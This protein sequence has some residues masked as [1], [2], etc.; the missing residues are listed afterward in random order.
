MN[1]IAVAGGTGVVGRRAVAALR[2]R[3]AQVRVLSRDTG[4]DLLTGAGLDEA[5]DGV[6]AVVDVSNISTTKAKRSVAFFETATSNLLRAERRAGVEH[7]VTLSIV[8]SDRVDL[9]YYAGKRRQEE[10]V[11]TGDVPWTILRATQFHEFAAQV[12]GQMRGPVVVVPRMRTQPVAAAEVGDLLATLALDAPAGMAE[13]LAGPEV[14]E[15][16]DLVR[17]LLRA[18]HA[19]RLTLPVRLPGEVGRGLAGGALL[20]R[21]DG[22]RGRQTWDS[23]LAGVVAREQAEAGATRS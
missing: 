12:A 9:G 8:G 3:G 10:L 14:H 6:T 22:P 16:P 15:L 19:R 1:T 7:H 13:E 11:R 20:P 4:F 2:E 17:R 21:G 18:R 23:W 5:L